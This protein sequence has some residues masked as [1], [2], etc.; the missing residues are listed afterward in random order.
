MTNLLR[1]VKKKWED[2]CDDKSWKLICRMLLLPK[3]PKKL[4]SSAYLTCSSLQELYA[5]LNKMASA[6]TEIFVGRERFATLLMM[7]LTE[8]VM[9]WLSDDQSFWEEIEE[10]PRA[11]GPL[12]LQQVIS[13]FNFARVCFL[14]FSLQNLPGL[15]MTANIPFHF[16]FLFSS[17]W[18]CSLSSFLGKGISYLGMCI[19]SYWRSLIERWESF[20]LRGWTLIGISVFLG[21]SHQFHPC[22]AQ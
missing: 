6:A 12:G 1:N 19:K 8:T 10:G 3:F 22:R 5:K 7:R 2:T 9:L 17:T 15:R 4:S 18:I 14:H 20:L 16:T 11:L 13:F 21:S